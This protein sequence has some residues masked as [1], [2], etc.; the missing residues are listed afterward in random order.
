ML[1]LVGFVYELCYVCV[2]G[3]GNFGFG[4]CVDRVGRNVC[5]LV[6][7]YDVFG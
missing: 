7:R 6:G 3:L 2:I 4:I 5:L 1:I